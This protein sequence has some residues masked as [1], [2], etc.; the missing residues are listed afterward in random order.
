MVGCHVKATRQR[1]AMVA[2]P[3][4]KGGES[5][6]EAERHTVRLTHLISVV[7]GN[8]AYQPNQYAR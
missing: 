2:R 8:C 5:E 1:G 6:P 3:R 4:M 7:S